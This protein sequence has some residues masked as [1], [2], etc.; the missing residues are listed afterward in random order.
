MFAAAFGLLAFGAVTYVAAPS[1][2]GHG[3]WTL[4][5]LI[6]GVLPMCGSATLYVCGSRRWACAYVRQRKA[7]FVAGAMVVLFTA[8]FDCVLYLNFRSEPDAGIKVSWDSKSGSFNW[9][10]GQVKLP[11]GFTYASRAGSDS[12]VGEFS[13]ES[14][15]TVITHDIGEL[16]GGL[17]SPLVSEMLIEGSRVRFDH[18]THVNESGKTRFRFELSFPDSGCAK[19]SLE[20]FDESKK[21]ILTSIADSFHPADSGFSWIRPY[22]PEVLRSDCRLMMPNVGE[23]F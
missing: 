4:E 1:D 11:P 17:S 12:A 16:G 23:Q 2:P 9:G 5:R 22:L 3:L 10:R 21:A 14:G 19:F 20:S 13:A 18:T 8:I 6:W 15:T 7:W